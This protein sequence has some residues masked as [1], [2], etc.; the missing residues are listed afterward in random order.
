MENLMPSEVARLVLGYL[1]ASGCNASWETFLKESPDLKEYAECV[2]RGREYPTNIG[3]RNL[4]QFLDA[5]HQLLQCQVAETSSS[6]VELVSSLERVVDQLKAVLSQIHPVQTDNQRRLAG[7]SP[8]ASQQTPGGEASPTDHG[9]QG[10]ALD[11]D[12][13]TLPSQTASRSSTAPPSSRGR[14]FHPNGDTT[15]YHL[16]AVVPPLRFLPNSALLDKYED[17]LQPKDVALPRFEPPEKDGAERRPSIEGRLQD[18]FPYGH[19]ADVNCRVSYGEGFYA[20]MNHLSCGTSPRG[21]VENEEPVRD[22]GIDLRRRPAEHD[23][24]RTDLPPAWQDEAPQKR[25]DDGTS[26]EAVCHEEILKESPASEGFEAETGTTASEEIDVDGTSRDPSPAVEENC[27]PSTS[28]PDPPPSSSPASVPPPPSS[29]G[30]EPHEGQSPAVPRNDGTVAATPASLAGDAEAETPAGTEP[31]PLPTRVPDESSPRCLLANERSLAPSLTTPMKEARFSPGRYYSPRRKSLIPRRRLLSANSPLAK[32]GEEA[33]N[34]NSSE[35]HRELG[36]VLEELLNNFPFLEKLADNINRAVGTEPPA[37]A[38]TLGP[39]P[40]EE[41]SSPKRMPSTQDMNL[42]ESVIKDILSRTENDPVFEEVLSQMCDKIETT[43]EID[44]V[45]VTPKSKTPSSRCRRRTPGGSPLVTPVRPAA[46]PTNLLPRLADRRPDSA[47]NVPCSLPSSSP[48]VLSS[49]TLSNNPTDDG[50]WSSRSSGVP[51]QRKLFSGTLRNVPWLLETFSNLPSDV[52][53]QHEP[54]PKPAESAP[55]QH[56]APLRPPSNAPSEHEPFPDSPS[57][58]ESGRETPSNPSSNVRSQ[59]GSFPEGSSDEPLRRR[60]FS[61][62][63]S[64]APER[65]ESFSNPP[66]NS[67]GNRP[68]EAEPRRSPSPSPDETPVPSSS[69]ASER[70]SFSNLLPRVV[71]P[72]SNAN[73]NW[74]FCPNLPSNVVAAQNDPSSNRSSDVAEYRPPSRSHIAMQG[75]RSGEGSDGSAVRRRAGLPSNLPPPRVQKVLPPTPSSRAPSRSSPRRKN[76]APRPSADPSASPS[77]VPVALGTDAGTVQKSPIKIVS[78]TKEGT[79]TVACISIP[80]P[81]PGERGGSFCNTLADIVDLVLTPNSKATLVAGSDPLPRA[82]TTVGWQ[83]A[84]RV[85]LCTGD[86]ATGSPALACRGGTVVLGASPRSSPGKV[87]VLAGSSDG[88]LYGVVRAAPNPPSSKRLPTLQ[89]KGPLPPM[90]RF[91]LAQPKQQRKPTASSVQA[92]RMKQMKQTSSIFNRDACI[93]KAAEAARRLERRPADDPGGTSTTRQ[94]E[95]PGRPREAKTQSPRLLTLVR[96]A[97]SRRARSGHHVRALDFGSDADAEAAST[98]EFDLS[99]TIESIGTSLTGVVQRVL[100]S[101][102]KGGNP[103]KRKGTS[104]ESGTEPKKNREGLN[105][106]GLDVDKFLN[107]IH[108]G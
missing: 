50:V 8:C 100:R 86:A 39:I 75:R 3:G 34:S 62:P 104:A 87:A 69:T 4:L 2:R 91:R 38:R 77:R 22:T 106:E 20:F 44:A 40:E 1:K 65:R 9:R 63:P 36:P 7:D 108:Q 30:Q 74:E 72:P 10:R 57:N 68:P 12:A 83:E 24:R 41:L 28:N 48:S 88:S 43:T 25:P 105:L 89:P 42:P 60:S 27:T 98:G 80:D 55:S 93:S 16:R 96:A 18:L 15:A 107:V 71:S 19:V 61:D 45:L 33:G 99:R 13:R 54:R 6:S 66:S 81:T 94:A 32:Q 84:T 67:D 49:A 11:D 64:N 58:T 70:D 35:E 17:G 59:C 31:P 46:T 76:S 85:L 90:P 29:Q 53:W 92:K 95:P 47:A 21:Y 79:D 14:P 51:P 101:S 97:S 52:P 73:Q 103:R 82:E 78:C 26:A 56:E 5:G 102:A 23:V 37:E